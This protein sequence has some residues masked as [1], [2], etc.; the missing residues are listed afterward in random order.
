MSDSIKPELLAVHYDNIFE[1][2][3]DLKNRVITITDAIEPPLFRIIDAAM[4][5]MESLNNKKITIKINSTGGSVY[6][7]L[8]I[9]GRIKSSPCTIHTIGYGAV[10]SA[11]TLILASGH[12]RYMS[13]YGW[14]MMHEGHSEIE[15]RLTD[16]KNQI[17][18]IEREEV[19]WAKWMTDFT[20]VEQP[21]WIK[22]SSG[23]DVYLNAS[24]L[25]KLN[26]IDHI[27]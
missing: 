8:A 21:F 17:S 7:A 6:E 16:L 11:A 23:K 4:T 15:G 24:E 18:Q 25:L 26:V 5:E 2:G 14:F 20:K 9:V 22:V 12:K 3:I 10:M 1:R 19:T 27:I 13:K